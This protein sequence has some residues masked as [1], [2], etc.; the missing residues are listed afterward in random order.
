M[1]AFMDQVEVSSEPGKGNH[2]EMKKTIGKDEDMD[3]TIALIQNL[4]KGMTKQEH[5]LWR[6]YRTG[7]VYC[8]KIYGKGNRAGRSV[9]DWNDWITE[10]NR[11]V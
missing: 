1:T 4:T 5:R 2:C 6:K 10:S 11:Q 3:H 7:L 8:K 9:S